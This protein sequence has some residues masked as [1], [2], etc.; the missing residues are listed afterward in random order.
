MKKPDDVRQIIKRFIYLKKTRRTTTLSTTIISITRW[1][2]NE[3]GRTTLTHEN[4]ALWT[5]KKNENLLMV[6]T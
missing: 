4:R 5:L 3:V 6:M 1:Y 2:T